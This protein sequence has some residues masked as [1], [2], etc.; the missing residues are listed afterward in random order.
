MRRIFLNKRTVYCRKLCAS[1]SWRRMVSRRIIGTVADRVNSQHFAEMMPLSHPNP[2][3][4]LTLF[5][6][7]TPTQIVT[8][9]YPGQVF[10]SIIAHCRQAIRCIKIYVTITIS[11]IINSSLNRI[12]SIS[13]CT[14]I[15]CMYWSSSS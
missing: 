1:I 15:G 9:H 3:P 7:L 6:T 10:F 8:Q 11:G 5:V 12:M 2:N 13:M 4:D 14:G